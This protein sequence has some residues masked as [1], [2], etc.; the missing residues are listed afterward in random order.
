MSKTLISQKYSK[1]EYAG[2]SVTFP[3]IGNATFDK[4]GN[5]DVEEDQ[6]EE[7]ILATQESFDFEVSGV[8][9]EKTEDEKALD[10][11]KELLDIADEKELLTLV[12]ETGDEKLIFK[13]AAMSNEKIKKELVKRFKKS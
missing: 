1:K 13:A 12:R 6:I 3:V 9:K 4:D 5:L 8:V 7:F 11:Y 2:Q 10:E